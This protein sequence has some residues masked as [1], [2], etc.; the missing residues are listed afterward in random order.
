M[1][2][3]GIPLS[4]LLQIATDSAS[5]MTG[6]H[7]DFVAKLKKVAPHV[8]TIHCIIHRQHLA[9]KS[10]SNDMEEALKVATSTINFVKANALHDCLFEKLYEGDDHQT[11]LL[12]TEVRCLSKENS[13]VCLSE[14][15]DMVLIFAH[16]METSAHSKKQKGKAEILFSALNNSNTKVRIFYLVDLFEHVNQLNKTLQGRNIDLVDCAEKVRSFL[17][18]LSLWRMHLQ[19][20]EFVFFCNLAK[21][22]PSLE[23]IASCTNHLQKLKRRYDQKI[24]RYN[25]NKPTR[26]DYRYGTLWRLK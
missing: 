17:N 26:L 7:N 5:A 25:Q 20:N 9:A 2:N 23:V 6:K 15:W 19:K 1:H 13:L 21:T 22:A 24:S 10:L 18:K 16:H 4:N 8:M 11:L 3:N 14:M 12:H